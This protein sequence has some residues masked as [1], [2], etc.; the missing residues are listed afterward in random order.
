MLLAAEHFAHAP[1]WQWYIVVYFFLAGLSG[2]SFAL[3]TMLRI[4]GGR[5]DLG[6]SRLAFLVSLP[7][8]VLC[9]V[10]LTVDLG[11]PDRFWHMLIDSRVAQPELK[12]WSPMQLGAWA[13]LVYGVFSAI[14]FLEALHGAGWLRLPAGDALVKVMATAIGSVFL[15]A[16]TLLALF[17]C[18]YT[19]VLLSVSNQPVWSDSWAL[20]GLFMA[21]ALTGSAGLLVLLARNR[22]LGEPSLEKLSAGD[23]Y[24][25][26]MEAVLVVLFLITLAAAGTIGRAFGGASVLLW[27]VVL[28]GL[29][30]PLYG[31]GRGRAGGLVTLSSAAALLGVLALRTV[32]VF[33]GQY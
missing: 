20:G 25:I 3:G 5:A 33:S 30:L 15:A 32:V 19:G 4:F 22:R 8:L 9:P 1:N 6:A 2:G 18:A 17:I 29:V 11:R 27:I 13:L 7:A 28:A 21:S 31:H 23:R 26:A 10:L 16:G 12:Y 24:F 14:A